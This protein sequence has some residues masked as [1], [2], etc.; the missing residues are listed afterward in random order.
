MQ[1]SRYFTRK[2][3]LV[4]QTKLKK[5]QWNI[6]RENKRMNKRFKIKITL[7]D[8]QRVKFYKFR[9]IIYLNQIIKKLGFHIFQTIFNKHRKCFV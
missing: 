3:D 7:E 2:C 6:K 1:V 4:E 5:I 9:I 8:K